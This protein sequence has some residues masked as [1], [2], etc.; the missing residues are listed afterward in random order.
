MNNRVLFNSKFEMW[1]LQIYSF[2]I[3]KE[4]KNVIYNYNRIIIEK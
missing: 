4:I 3:V 2:D 1:F